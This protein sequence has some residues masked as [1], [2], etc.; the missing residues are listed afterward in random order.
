MFANPRYTR[1]N[2]P[3]FTESAH[4]TAENFYIPGLRPSIMNDE[5]HPPKAF[6]EL[7]L[8]LIPVE[9][10]RKGDKWRRTFYDLLGSICLSPEDTLKLIRHLSTLLRELFDDHNY[11]KEIEASAKR[12]KKEEEEDE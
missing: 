10:F 7:D 12:K 3:V 4:F 9:D 8:F 6:I 5:D 1:K 11:V 2:A